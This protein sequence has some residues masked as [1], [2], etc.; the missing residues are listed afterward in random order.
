[1][2]NVFSKSILLHMFLSLKEEYY[3]RNK[4]V[5][6][7]NIFSSKLIKKI[8]NKQINNITFQFPKS[9]IKVFS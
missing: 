7:K 4:N 8:N 6:N 1:M 3:F 2:E 9:F 5:Y